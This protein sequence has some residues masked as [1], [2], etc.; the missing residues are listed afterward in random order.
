MREWK[1]RHGQICRAGKCRSENIG[2]VLQ[3][4]AKCRSGNIGTVMRGWK[5]QEWNLWEDMCLKDLNIRLAFD[6]VKSLLMSD[7]PRKYLLQKLLRYVER[8]WII[9]STVGPQRL[10]VR[11][12]QS[13]TNNVLESF[14]SALR[15]RVKFAH[16][17]VFAFLA[18][19]QRAT[20][21]S[22][23]MIIRRAKKKTNVVNDKRR[24]TCL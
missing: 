9:K 4:V 6:D 17:N 13:R 19:L 3:G 11:D 10:F 15:S 20:V 22:C 5:M 14:H 7:S 24:K 23:G 2:T 21:D 16:P 12:N 1:N 18:H 8:Q